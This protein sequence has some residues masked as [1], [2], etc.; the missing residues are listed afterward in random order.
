VE[1]TRT[2]TRGTES[3]GGGTQNW[4]VSARK[5]AGSST[6][7]SAMGRQN[8]GRSST[9]RLGKSAPSKAPGQEEDGSE[10]AR[11]AENVS[12][13]RGIHQQSRATEDSPSDTDRS[14]A[15]VIAP[16]QT[17][18]VGDVLGEIAQPIDFDLD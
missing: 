9:D 10:T 15:V 5:N 13:I 12:R 4:S 8:M 3:S 2:D 6:T 18:V 7:A 16:N 11:V 1:G 14:V 17:D